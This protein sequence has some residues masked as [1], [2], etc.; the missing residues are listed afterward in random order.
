MNESIALKSY[1]NSTDLEE[2]T[3]EMIA[4][5]V[6]G[7]E[8]VPYSHQ[9]ELYRTKLRYLSQPVIIYDRTLTKIL[10]KGRFEGVNEHGHA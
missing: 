4:T 10:A 6:A 5:E 1:C 7:L 3:L 2:L 9:L 8:S